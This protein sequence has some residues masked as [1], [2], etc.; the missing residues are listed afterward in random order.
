MR[1]IVARSTIGDV[2][3]LNGAITGPLN[4]ATTNGTVIVNPPSN[5]PVCN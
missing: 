3:D 1:A 5:L 2:Y 4:S